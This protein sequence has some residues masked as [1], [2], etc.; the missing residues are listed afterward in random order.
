MQDIFIPVYQHKY[1]IYPIDNSIAAIIRASPFIYLYIRANSKV[2]WYG[3]IHNKKRAG[4]VPNPR[5]RIHVG[6]LS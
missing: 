4:A 1:S 6:N 3:F 2:L 5:V